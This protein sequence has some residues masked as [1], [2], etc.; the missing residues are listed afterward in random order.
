MNQLDEQ[1]VNKL[2]VNFFQTQCYQ[3]GGYGTLCIEDPFDSHNDVGKSSYGFPAVKTTFEFTY[4]H[5]LKY[6]T[7]ALNTKTNDLRYVILL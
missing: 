7:P 4:F 5:L 6:V 3:G 2:F 1:V